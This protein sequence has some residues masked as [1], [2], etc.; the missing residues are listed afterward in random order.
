MARPH[1][2]TASFIHPEN[3]QAPVLILLCMNPPPNSS[4]TPDPHRERGD[5][6]CV[7][8]CSGFAPLAPYLLT[9][10]GRS[11][12][13]CLVAVPSVV[14]RI[15]RKRSRPRTA[16]KALGTSTQVERIFLFSQKNNTRQGQNT[17]VTGEETSVIKLGESR[18]ETIKCRRG[19]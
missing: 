1:Y 6:C 2:R 10:C 9:P 19:V 5:R 16:C 15:W 3:D 8:D 17:T 14:Q 11:V 18:N 4:Y 13:I 7:P 12:C